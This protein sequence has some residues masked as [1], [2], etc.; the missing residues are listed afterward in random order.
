MCSRPWQPFGWILLTA[1]L[2]SVGFM[3][4][5]NGSEADRLGTEWNVSEGGIPGTWVRRGH[6]D[7]WDAQWRN[8]AV[9]VLA[10]T[11]AG[12]KVRIDR[13]DTSG[14]SAG[15]TAIYEGTIAPDNSVQGIQTVTAPG[16]FTQSWQG[17]IVAGAALPPPPARPQPQAIAPLP[18]LGATLVVVYPGPCTA[19]WTRQQAGSYDAMTM[20]QGP[21]NT[22]FRER[23]TVESF[24]GHGVVIVRPGYGKYRGAVSADGKTVRGS[25]DWPGCTPTYRWTGYIDWNWNDAPPLRP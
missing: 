4:G 21:T 12:D 11:V 1:A 18:D 5:A 22:S 17:R 14:P 3:A 23:L 24:D 7:T 15:L 19:I 9:A 13:R 8:G 2:C 25:C 6:S 10:I 20:C 16:R